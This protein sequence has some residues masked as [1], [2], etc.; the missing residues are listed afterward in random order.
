MF[1][2][3]KTELK[4]LFL[5][6]RSIFL[7]LIIIAS[8]LSLFLSY[9]NGPKS[10]AMEFAE[11]KYG[12]QAIDEYELY[13]R[14]DYYRNNNLS[15]KDYQFVTNQLDEIKQNIIDAQASLKLTSENKQ[16]F[17][18]KCIKAYSGLAQLCMQVNQ[19]LGDDYDYLKHQDI[20]QS[21]KQKYKL[22]DYVFQ[23]NGYINPSQVSYIRCFFPSI[24]KCIEIWD[25]FYDNHMNY[26]GDYGCDSTRII[27][28][29]F[30]DLMPLLLVFVLP[31]LYCDNVSS[32]R[33]QGTLKTL[34][35]LPHMRSKYA[36]IRPLLH[37]S[38]AILM[39]IIPIL[40]FSLCLG[41]HDRFQNINYPML[42][43]PEGRTSFTFGYSSY[44]E[45][46]AALA[47]MQHVSEKNVKYQTGMNTILYS[48]RPGTNTIDNSIALIPLWQFLLWCTLMI[49]LVILFMTSCI[50]VI[51]SLFHSYVVGLIITL[52]VSFIGYSS[53]SFVNISFVQ[54]F[55]PFQYI[56]PVWIVGGTSAYPYLMGICVLLGWSIILLSLSKAIMK[57]KSI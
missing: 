7:L 37:T 14:L 52:I 28:F 46:W 41:M 8:I 38:H 26:L 2:Y 16:D 42:S 49:M 1:Q 33:K 23:P 39:L 29:Y 11:L 48:T 31:L 51:T 5:N 32:N 10:I 56:Y 18:M 22:K 54:A 27:L 45:R 55:N 9:Q 24:V 34:A 44:K 15:E 6:K 50:Q 25:R 21:I 13:L 19:P 36:I 30:R 4:Y 35:T 43:Y 12:K 20:Y 3:F 57:R 47:Q 40:C 53:S 17:Y